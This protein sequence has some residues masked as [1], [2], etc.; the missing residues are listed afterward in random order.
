MV[1]RNRILWGGLNRGNTQAMQ[2]HGPALGWPNVPSGVGGLVTGYTQPTL[3]RPPRKERLESA[4]TRVG[5][6]G[7]DLPNATYDHHEGHAESIEIVYAP[8]RV[9]FST[10]NSP[11]H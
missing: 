3:N 8:E 11:G 4:S 6:T 1:G 5:Y 9:D 2:P 7:G 10:V